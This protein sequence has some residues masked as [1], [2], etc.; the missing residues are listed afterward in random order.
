M[1]TKTPRSLPRRFTNDVANLSK[2]P[3]HVARF[4]ASH[5]FAES[6]P[7]Y[8]NFAGSVTVEVRTN[9]SNL[10]GLQEQRRAL[11]CMIEHENS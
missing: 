1:A 4:V 11:V 2:I 8:E 6:E 3:A 9:G 10:S 5:V 7:E